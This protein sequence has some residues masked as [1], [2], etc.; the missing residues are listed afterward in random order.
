M[1]EDQL[2]TSGGRV[3]AVTGLGGTVAEAAERSRRAADAIQFEGKYFRRDIGWRELQ[4][5]A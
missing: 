4:R 3:F 1:H 2:V 5:N